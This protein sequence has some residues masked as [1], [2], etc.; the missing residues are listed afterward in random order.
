M[1][2]YPAPSKVPIGDVASSALDGVRQK[3]QEQIDFFRGK[4]NVPTERWDDIW[5]GAH[6]KAF[7]VAGAKKADLLKDL[8]SAVEGAVEGESIGAFRKR[9]FE[10]VKKSGWTGWTGEG[11]EYGRNWRTRVIY[12]TNVATSYAAGRW[13]QLHDPDLLSVRPFWR[14]VHADGVI[15]PRPLHQAWGASR[16]T[17]RYDHPFWKTH[18]PPNGWGCGCRV[19]AVRGPGAGDATEPPVGWDSVDAKTGAPLG[20]DKGW[21]YA[22]GAGT[23]VS[24][25]EL[26]QEKLITYPEAIARALCADVNRYINT[27]SDVAGFVQGVMDD[28]KRKDGLWLGFVVNDKDV[29]AV[30]GSDVKG[31]TVTIPADAPRHVRDHHE[32]DGG[33]QRTPTPEDYARILSVLTEADR[34]VNGNVVQGMER[35]VAE[36]LIDGELFRAVFEVRPGKRNRSLSLVTLAIKVRGK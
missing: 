28:G 8:N 3:F 25:R 14:Y 12:Q 13:Q 36:K 22:P 31:F 5:Q 4:L 35:V 2:D 16:L 34:L 23:D 26:V 7:M 18:F 17:L 10:D 27:Q 32:F 29:S 19:V 11:S 20:I 6:D 21:A 24:L 33:G 1:S 15:H 30:V 9:F